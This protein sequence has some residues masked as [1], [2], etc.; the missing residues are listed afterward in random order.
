M[1]NSATAATPPE[2]LLRRDFTAN[3]RIKSVRARDS[4]A[5]VGRQRDRREPGAGGYYAMTNPDE[6]LSSPSHG[7]PTLKLEH[8][9]TYADGER[10][11][12]PWIHS[13][14]SAS[15]QSAGH[16][17]AAMTTTSVLVL[18]ALVAALVAVLVWGFQRVGDGPESHA[19]TDHETKRR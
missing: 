2:P 17:L 9:S 7:E 1:G 16:S 6:W 14:R 11:D 13:A 5:A 18:A 4:G 15:P 12:M 3:K 19:E 10:A 8:D